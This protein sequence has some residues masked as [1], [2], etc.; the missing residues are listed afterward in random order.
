VPLATP[1]FGGSGLKGNVAANK[2]KRQTI[3][4]FRPRNRW[5]IAEDAGVSRDVVR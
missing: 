2:A 5:M 3:P 4:G 1:I